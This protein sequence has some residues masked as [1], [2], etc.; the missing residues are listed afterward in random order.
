M[1]VPWV[2]VAIPTLGERESLV[3]TV[4][5]VLTSAARL[6]APIEVLIVWSSRS[7]RPAWA[8]S[9]PDAVREVVQARR[10]LSLAKNTALGEARS[11]LILFTDDDTE[12]SAGWVGALGEALSAGAS[13]V[14]GPIVVRWPVREPAWLTP[15]ARLLFGH[16][17]NGPVDL[18][19]IGPGSMNGANLGIARSD[20]LAI[21]GF[22]SELGIG[23]RRALLGEETDLCRRATSSGLRVRY[24]ASASILHKVSPGLANRRTYWRKSY[25]FGRTMAVLDKPT[26]AD[27]HPSRRAASMVRSIAMVPFGGATRRVG[28]AAFLAGSLSGFLTGAS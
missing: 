23:K 24:V 12:V 7:D 5:S 17:D 25:S 18:D 21:G 9:F 15:E 26:A 11:S 2:S 1:T 10:G 28:E 16:L 27:F 19:I 8:P 6:S 20:V 22:A 14:G 3:D 13:I 4:G